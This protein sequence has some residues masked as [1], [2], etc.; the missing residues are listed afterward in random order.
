MNSFNRRG[1]VLGSGALALSACS[2]GTAS[3]ERD[4]IDRR[5]SATVQKMYQELPFTRELSNQAAGMLI[6]PKVTKGGFI[7]GGT[8]GEGSLLIGQAPV[9]YYNVVGASI[10][11]QIGAQQLS[12]ALFF[13]NTDRLRQFREKDG[14]T[15]GAD[16]EYVLLE[17]GDTAAVDTQTSKKEV[18][19]V[20]FGQ[21]GLLAGVSIEGS[22]YNRVIR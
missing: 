2:R 16:L 19:A 18:F 4:K 8:F 9:D 22:K 20:A 5:V 14:W 11:F 17:D 13:M 3:N 6:M 12:T 7:Y 10:G 1:F 15:L 21:K